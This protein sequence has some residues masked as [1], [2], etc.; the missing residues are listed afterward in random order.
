MEEI[1]DIEFIGYF[2]VKDLSFIKLDRRI[3][4]S[5]LFRDIVRSLLILSEILEL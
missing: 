1:L 4:I 5:S 2:G 3:Y